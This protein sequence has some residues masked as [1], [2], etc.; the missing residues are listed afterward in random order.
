M[1]PQDKPEAMLVDTSINILDHLKGGCHAHAER[2]ERGL[3]TFLIQNGIEVSLELGYK[4]CDSLLKTDG[5]KREISKDALLG[6]PRM[7]TSH[8]L[9]SVPRVGSTAEPT[10]RGRMT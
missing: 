6:R 10:G 5:K 3:H 7:D 8:R 4:S 9:W 2:V 1:H